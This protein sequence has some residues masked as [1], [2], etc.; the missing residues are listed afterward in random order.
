MARALGVSEQPPVD[1]ITWALEVDA[2]ASAETVE[3]VKT[4]AD[5]RCPGVFCIRNPISLETRASIS[6]AARS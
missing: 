2:D 1:Q 3:R 4:L 6:G 5:Q